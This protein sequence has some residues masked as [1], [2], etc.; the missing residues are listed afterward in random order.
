MMQQL[1]LGTLDDAD[2]FAMVVEKVENSWFQLSDIC[3]S[4]GL[5]RTCSPVDLD[6][7][8]LPCQDNSPANQHRQFFEGPRA[9]TYV[10]YARKHRLLRTPV[11]IIE[12][13]TEFWLGLTG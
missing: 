1:P 11:V 7:S 6:L 12:N 8:G 13:H 3:R 4:H 5:C 9:K 2:D 10:L